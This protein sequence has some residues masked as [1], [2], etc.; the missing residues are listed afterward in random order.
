MSAV[1]LCSPVTLLFNIYLF[2]YFS[3]VCVVWLCETMLY[4]VFNVPTRVALLISLYLQYNDNKGFL[5]STL[6]Y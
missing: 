2:I 1:A 3:V 6:S 5:H 4:C